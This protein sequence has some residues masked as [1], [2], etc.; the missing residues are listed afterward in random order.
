MIFFDARARVVVLTAACLLVAAIAQP[1]LAAPGDVQF[2][3]KKFCVTGSSDGVAGWSFGF[4]F[5]GPPPVP[6]KADFNV[7][8]LPMGAGPEALAQAFV[9]AVDGSAQFGVSARID[10][11]DPTCFLVTLLFESEAPLGPGAW[12]LAVGPQNVPPNCVVTAAGCTFNPT[13]FLL[14]PAT[15]GYVCD[16][17]DGCPETVTVCHIPPGHPENAHTIGVCVDAVPAHLA[18]GDFLGDCDSASPTPHTAFETNGLESGGM[19]VFGRR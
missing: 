3:T 4:A 9:D 7:D 18:H 17:C 11:D 14:P 8:P 2:V 10:P 6:A 5:P 19:E 1:P 16:Y 15:L 13:V 12:D